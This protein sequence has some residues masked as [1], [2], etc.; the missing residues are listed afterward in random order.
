[1]K[2]AFSDHGKYHI[3]DT[4]EVGVPSEFIGQSGMQILNFT[5]PIY[6]W[7]LSVD[8]KFDYFYS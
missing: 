8:K 2:R 3:A 7:L 5:T 4:D 1:L 6:P